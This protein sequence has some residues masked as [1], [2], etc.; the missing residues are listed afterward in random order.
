[1]RRF[2]YTLKLI[3]MGMAVFI[4]LKEG[5]SLESG[6]EEQLWFESK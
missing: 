2:I 1:M 3:E 5:N 6:G 4:L